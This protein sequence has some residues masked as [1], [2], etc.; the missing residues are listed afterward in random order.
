MNWSYLNNYGYWA[1]VYFNPSDYYTLSCRAINT[2]GYGPYSYFYANVQNR[3][4]G[5]PNPASD[6]VNVE[7]GNG[8]SD[9]SPGASITY[10]I[11]LYDGMGNLLRQQKTNGGTIQF[12]V[13]NLAAGL[14]FLHI[15]DGVNE[16]PEIQK[17][18]VA[19]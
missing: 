3:Q 9:R 18:E 7:V 15:Y 16:K 17:I 4:R 2:C 1:A 12:N 10:D 11:R 6:V 8:S 14:Y 13:S 5:Y 19:R